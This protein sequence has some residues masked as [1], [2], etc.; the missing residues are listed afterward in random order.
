[1]P[2]AVKL[3][4]PWMG[5]DSENDHPMPH[6]QPSMS[7]T[8][9]ILDLKHSPVEELTGN[10]KTLIFSSVQRQLIF[11]RLECDFC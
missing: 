8:A 4:G 5:T 6:P 3:S 11:F 2:A 7:M 9:L 1:M 10:T